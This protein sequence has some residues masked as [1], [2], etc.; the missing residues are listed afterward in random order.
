MS[1]IDY[2]IKLNRKSLSVFKDR[3]VWLMAFRDAR[4]NFSRLFLFIAALITGIAALVAIGSLNY[5]LQKDLDR[6]AKE[7]LGADLVINGSRMF[8]DELI[9]L[10]DSTR[11][12]QALEADMASM[13][14]FTSTGESRLVRVVALKG[15]FPFYGNIVTQPDDAYSRMKSGAVVMLDETLASQY[16]MSSEDS[17]RV[18]QSI[19]QMG[20]E[21]IKIPG[22]G[23]ILATFTPSVYMSMD[24]LSNTGL[25]QF[26]SRVNYR[27]FIKTNNDQEAEEL[28]EKLKPEIKKLGHSFETVNGR[29]EGLGEGFLAVYRFFTLLAFMAL[30]LGCI[31]V[32]SSVTLY[33]REKR[34]EVAVLRC[35]GSS[36]WQAFNI[37]FIQVIVVGIIGSAIGVMLGAA[38]QYLMPV[39]FKDFIPVELQM[40]VSYEAVIEGFLVGIIV[41]IL[42]TLLPLVEIRFISP[43]SVLR[44]DFKLPK[45]ISKLRMFAIIM[46]ALFP[47]A[48]AS[49]QTRSWLSGLIFFAGL[50][51]ALLFLA[52]VAKILL[53]GVRKFFPSRSSFVWKHSL[54][55]LFRPNNQTTILI[56][57]IGLGAFIL[58][59][60]STVQHSL[61]SQVEFRD[62][63]NQSN[64]VMFDIQPHQKDEIVKLL[65]DHELP[66]MQMVPIVT[67]RIAELKGK[68]VNELQEDRTD[69]IPNWAI[70]REYRVTYRDSLTSSEFMMKGEM[71]AYH[72]G[73]RDS[74][75][76]TISEGMHENLRVGIGDSIVFDIQGVPLKA[77]IAGIRKVDWPKDPPNFIFVFPA[78]ILEQAPQIFV[79][80]TRIDNNESA[81]RFQAELVSSMPNVSLIDLRL[82]LSTV[83]ELFDKVAL[84]IRFMALFSIITGMVVLAGAVINSKFARIREYVLLRTVGASGKQINGITLIEY[85]YLGFFAALTGILLSVFAGWLLAKYF[86]RIEFA[87]SLADFGLLAIS[88]MVLTM[89]IG[90]Y[91][92]REVV[93]TPPLQVL[94]RENG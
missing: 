89:L 64:T 6:N 84:V 71:H 78:G 40:Q 16:V 31:G 66:V 4:R 19:F 88:I 3:W 79:A 65:T 54:S 52:L 86:F 67:C 82:I 76:V 26:G 11:Y 22:G 7:L 41:A 60:L 38:I 34:E 15:N 50:L 87:F 72:P 24:N 83:N 55:N 37:Y 73:R 36:G 56:T 20:G 58:A 61:L 44:T 1:N 42:F 35:I 33:A 47:I 59:T 80:T 46:I 63:A 28:L 92:S 17:V 49:Y 10:V 51:M 69:S 57:T 18:G 77:F 75:Y 53:M 94:R 12:E 68:S 2:I 45:R 62:R 5:S 14:R 8:E 81:N 91:N 25:V 27:W 9:A 13:V 48:V 30:I 32:A 85:A 23:G 70:T 29:K 93:R 21:V 43:L 90:W 39:V 74:V